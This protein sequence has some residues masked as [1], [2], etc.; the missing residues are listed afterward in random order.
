MRLSLYILFSLALG[1]FSF[2]NA[3]EPSAK[4]DTCKPAYADIYNFNLGDVFQYREISTSSAG[5]VGI[6]QEIISQYM[7]MDKD[8]DSNIY[9]YYVSGWKEI[10]SYQNFSN[11]Q[12]EE[13][14]TTKDMEYIDEYVVYV[15]SGANFLNRCSKEI[16]HLQNDC[17]LDLGLNDLY[18]RVQTE[19]SDSS[20]F[21]IIGGESNVMKYNSEEILE[22]NSEI[23]FKAKYGKG[24][25]LISQEF[26]F[27]EYRETI[28][29]EAYIKSDDTVGV[30]ISNEDY[31]Y[32]AATNNSNTISTPVFIYPTQSNGIVYIQSS[33]ID[34]Q[35][36]QA[37][38]IS[39]QIVYTELFPS[40]RINLSELKSGIY[41]IQLKLA[42]GFSK[43]FKLLMR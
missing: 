26:T 41:F 27:F 40:N 43:S 32:E 3:A 36:V 6:T 21:K 17:F 14:D 33:G 2:L 7:V 12:T 13:S 11:N 42:D 19:Y 28:E 9:S 18:S 1:T 20:V 15:D 31:Y 23:Y 4:A 29:L 16:I 35:S 24:L 22:T 5:G 38:N 34:V 8:V 37:I 10:L 30:I 25:G 39:G